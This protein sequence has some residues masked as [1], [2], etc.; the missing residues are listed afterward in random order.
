MVERYWETLKGVGAEAWEKAEG[1]IIALAGQRIPTPAS[2]LKIA[3]EIERG[4]IEELNDPE[5]DQ[6]KHLHIEGEIKRLEGL[7]SGV[8]T[9]ARKSRLRNLKAKLLKEAPASPHGTPMRRFHAGHVRS[10]RA[11]GLDTGGRRRKR[12]ERVW[13]EMHA[14]PPTFGG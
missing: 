14:I 2:M 11:L 5:L 7:P 4:T 8:M 6:L 9:E 3:R 12:V 10:D 1:P 13:N